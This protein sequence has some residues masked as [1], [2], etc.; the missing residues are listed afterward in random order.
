MILD[1]LRYWVTEMHVDGFRFDLTSALARTG[2]D[3]D[4]RSD[5]LTTIQQDPVLRYV[6]LIAEPWDASMDG[7]RVGSFPPPWTEWND[8]YRDTV[9]DFWRPGS[10]G[11]RDVASRLAGSS[12]LYADDGRSPYSSINFV[13]AHD[14]FTLRDLVSYDA[15]AQRGQRRATTATAPTTTGPG[16]AGSRAR[17]TTPR[18]SRC[19]A[20]RP[21]T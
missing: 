16:T 1:S 14:G 15:Q 9:R 18:S 19:A 2:H 7:Y 4:M 11:V 17:P 20:A 8:R 6:K 3:I 13:T 12:D 5:F 21:P 10:G